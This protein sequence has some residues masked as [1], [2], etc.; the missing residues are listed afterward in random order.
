MSLWYT[1]ELFIYYAAIYL[2]LQAIF[3]KLRQSWPSF[4]FENLK[5]VVNLYFSK[6][7]D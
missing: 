3:F 7:H 2:Y 4:E 6:L 5:G 1:S